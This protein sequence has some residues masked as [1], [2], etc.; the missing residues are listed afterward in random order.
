MK[1]GN[2]A[3]KASATGYNTS[4]PVSVSVKN[5]TNQLIKLNSIA[6]KTPET[7]TK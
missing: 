1:S 7:Q 6:P 2:Y 4:I 3:I 5:K